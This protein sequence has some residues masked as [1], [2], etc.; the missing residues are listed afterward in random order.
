M[1]GNYY[2]NSYYRNSGNFRVKTFLPIKFSCQ[3][4]FVP[5]TPYRSNMCNIEKWVWPGDEATYIIY[6]DEKFCAF[7]FRTQPC[8][9]NIFE[10]EN[11]PNYGT[12]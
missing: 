7:N 4:I 8:V 2:S 12:S 11:F 9:R 1:V 6:C 10:D 3:N 5:A